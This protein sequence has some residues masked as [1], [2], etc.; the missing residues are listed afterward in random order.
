MPTIAYDASCTSLF[1]PQSTPPLFRANA[2]YDSLQLC[3][4]AARLA[5]FHD[6]DVLRDAL[7]IVGFD[8]PEIF[9]DPGTDSH[10]YGAF[11]QADKLA[12]LAFRGTQPESF[13]NIETNLEAIL[14]PWPESGGRVHEG[15]AKAAR[16]LLPVV[17]PWLDTTAPAR[18]T[19]LVTGHSLG[20][21]IATLIASV[22][23]PCQLVTIGCPRVGDADFNATL[24]R[25]DNTRFVDCSDLVTELPPEFGGYVHT[26]PMTYINRDGVIDRNATEAS[27]VIDR[28]VAKATYVLEYAVHAGNV[29]L[30]ELADHTPINYIRAVFP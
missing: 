19:L 13:D 8:Q 10:G 15:F 3:V 22:C 28:G 17:K 24:N 4:E 21:A 20:A 18:K 7:A 6:E 27:A 29:R 16:A 5:Y 1:T 9:T 2:N 26:T 11:R 23:Q 30:R 25:V 12:L 14:T